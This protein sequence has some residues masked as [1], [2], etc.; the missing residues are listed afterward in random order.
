MGGA[1]CKLRNTPAEERMNQTHKVLVVAQDTRLAMTLVSWLRESGCE[2]AVTTS[3]SAGRDQLDARLAFVIAEV[4][5]GAYNGLH[6]A[7]RARAK[8]IPA[9]VF[10]EANPTTER[11]A[12]EVG[13]AFLSPFDLENAELQ[14][15]LRAGVMPLPGWRPSSAASQASC[16]NAGTGRDTDTYGGS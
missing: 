6:L 16:E 14:S 12:R 9:V 7:L 1:A 2:P 3:Y 8:G 5:L 10:G 11:E 15:L 13:A 4:R